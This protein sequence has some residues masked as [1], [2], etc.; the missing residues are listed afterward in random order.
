MQDVVM[1]DIDTGE[2][3]GPNGEPI[4]SRVNHRR[5]RDAWL[6]GARRWW[7]VAAG[8]ALVVAGT[9]VVANRRESARLAAIAGVPGILSPVDGRVAELWRND[10]GQ[11]SGLAELAGRLVGVEN[12]S[13]GSADVVALDPLTGTA[14]WRTAAR[15]AGGVD[16]GAHC[17][18]PDASRPADGTTVSPVIA[19]VVLDEFVTVVNDAVG[20]ARYPSKARLLVVDAA[21][22]AVQ[23][24]D[25]TDPSTSVS[26]IGTDLVT[27]RVDADG[28]VRVTRTDPRGTAVRWTFSSPAPVG[29][30][31]FGHAATWVEVTGD[32]VT[33]RS[34]AA[35]YEGVPGSSASSW[36]LSASGDV[37]RSRIDDASEWFGGGISVLLAGKVLAEPTSRASSTAVI[38]LATGRSFTAD[39]TQLA[40]WADDGSLPGLLIMQS[41]GGDHLIGYDLASGRPAWTVPT[42]ILVGGAVIIDGRIVQAG[43]AAVTSI[44]G[45]T[46]ETIWATPIV[47]PAATGQDS[48]P[49]MRLVATD[50]RLVLLAWTDGSSGIVLS[51]Y[52]LDDG[53]A[54]WETHVDDAQSVNVIAGKLFGTSEHGLVALG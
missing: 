50:G 13:D 27:G 23:S 35:T 32:L 20:E 14:I 24:D 36:V 19:C 5:D 22:G 28:R 29:K 34:I 2:V 7:P 16:V 1:V 4:A 8:L 17:A 6:R 47:H 12:H 25:Q 52:G 11:Y 44:D 38:D 49:E 43:T 26:F 3:V 15:P 33:I 53:K 42:G 51:A 18:F 41:P 30:D 45:R 37:I 54:R 10:A 39:A 21:S 31:A 9:M 48:Q 40:T 46:G